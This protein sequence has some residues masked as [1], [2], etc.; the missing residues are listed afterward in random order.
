MKL[1]KRNRGT[2]ILVIVALTAGAAIGALTTQA[3]SAHADPASWSAFATVGSDTLQDVFNAFAGAEDPL[4]YGATTSPEAFYLPMYSPPSVGAETINSFD[5]LVPG[6]SSQQP[7]TIVTKINA[8]TIDR[9]DGS[10]EGIT[11][12]NDSIYNM[13]W[14]AS[15]TGTGPTW[16]TGDVDFVRSALGPSVAGANYIFIPVSRD[17]VS[18]AYFDHSTRH[19]ANLTSVQLS[20][21]YSSANGTITVGS[22]TVEACLMQPRSD[23][24]SLWEAAIGVSDQVASA[25]V[26]ASG[27]RGAFEDDDGN[28][29]FTYASSLPAGTD[30]VIPFSVAAWIAQANGTAV[31]RSAMARGGGVDMG[32]IDQLGASYLGVAPNE[33]PNQTLLATSTYGHDDYVV[34]WGRLITA[35]IGANR[36]LQA[37]FDGSSSVICS[38]AAQATFVAFGFGTHLPNGQS[39]GMITITGNG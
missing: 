15:P 12:L 3:R 13:Q 27:C 31:D 17:A 16:V 32:N 29:F 4:T 23:N 39:C 7:S 30:A 36:R 6:Y 34:L 25:A 14:Q 24:R 1:S 38:S 35:R 21:L 26:A 2:V 5:A 37:L 11:M 9:P 28:G 22:D 8:A 19:L 10:T 18:Y 33:S 20:Q